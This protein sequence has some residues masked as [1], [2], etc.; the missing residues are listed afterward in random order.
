MNSNQTQADRSQR[1]TTN[2]LLA[3]IAG[4]LGFNALH[5]AGVSPE[6]TAF[7]Q[8]GGDEGLVS[9]A[10]Q[11]KVM[12]SELRNLSSRVERMESTLAKG[13]TVKVSDMPPVRLA[14]PSQMQA[15]ET[16]RKASK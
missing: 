12:I 9:A 10:E 13:L 7:A 2:I 1:R 11:R 15:K 4:L 6:S 14:D 3:A 8:A 5:Q 16:T